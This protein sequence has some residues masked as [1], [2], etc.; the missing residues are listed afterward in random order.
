M[1]KD[2]KDD[3]IK[4]L[5]AVVVGSYDITHNDIRLENGTLVN[6]FDFRD[7][8]LDKLNGLDD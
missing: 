1:N 8:L 2:L 3:I 5:S 6:W 7:V 4:L